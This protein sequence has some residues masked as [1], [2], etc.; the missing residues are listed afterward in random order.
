[1]T[2][3]DGRLTTVNT[4]YASDKRIASAPMIGTKTN[5]GRVIRSMP[6]RVAATGVGLGTSV[7]VGLGDGDGEVSGEGEG[8]GGGV[9]VGACRVKFAHGNGATLAQR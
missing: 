7:G 8:D 4:Q 3:R 2:G 5:G 1:M 9:G 6:L